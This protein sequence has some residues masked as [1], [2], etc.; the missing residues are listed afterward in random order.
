MTWNPEEVCVAKLLQDIK[1]SFAKKFAQ[2][3]FPKKMS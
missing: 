1:L 3:I 2:I